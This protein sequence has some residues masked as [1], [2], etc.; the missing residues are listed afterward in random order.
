MA[1]V[2]IQVQLRRQLGLVEHDNIRSLLPNE[3]VQV[4]LLLLRVEAPHIPHQDCQWDLGDAQVATMH[5]SM[6]N[7]LYMCLLALGD[8]LLPF[9]L[10]GVCI[11]SLLSAVCRWSGRDAAPPRR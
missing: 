6:L 8:V 3:P 9:I 4:P 2:P 7:L 1:V 11:P 5:L 10:S